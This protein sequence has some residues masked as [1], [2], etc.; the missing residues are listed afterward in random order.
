MCDPARRFGK[1][2]CAI[3]GTYWSIA[4]MSGVKENLFWLLYALD[5]DELHTQKQICDDWMF[6]KTTVNTLV[7]ECEA[8]GYITL[9]AIPG[10]KRELQICL[11][12]SGKAFAGQ[13]LKPVYEIERKAMAEVLEMRSSAFVA[14]FEF[15]D[16]ALRS[17]F[18]NDKKSER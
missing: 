11:T 10:H 16:A 2:M 18:Q 13:I 3:E 12:D 5:D 14:D 1:A 15:F 7:K 4:K 9:Q 8:A 6:P 17:A